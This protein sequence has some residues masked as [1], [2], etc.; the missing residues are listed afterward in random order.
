MNI[1]SVVASLL[2]AVA[3]VLVPYV[4]YRAARWARTRPKGAYVL[5]V[6]LAPFAAA[7]NVVDPDFRI[8]NE[9]NQT[10]KREEDDAGDPP[11]DEQEDRSQRSRLP[12]AQQPVVAD[13]DG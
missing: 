13:G 9:A 12:T 3:V 4:L 6:A 7:G 11:N 5:G 1:A 8:V 2:A 10:K